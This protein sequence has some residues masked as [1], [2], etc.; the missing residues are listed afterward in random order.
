MKGQK[1]HNQGPNTT[2]MYSLIDRQTND[3][4][5]VDLWQARTTQYK[6]FVADLMMERTYNYLVNLGEK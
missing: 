3:A 5:R 4:H 2:A 6:S 1:C